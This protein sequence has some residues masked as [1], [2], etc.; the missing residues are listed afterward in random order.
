MRQPDRIPIP[1]SPARGNTMTARLTLGIICGGRSPEHQIS[2][3]SA[4]NVIKAAAESFDILVVGITRNG[5]WL[6]LP[7]QD[8]STG[9]ESPATVQLNTKAGKPVSLVRRQDQAGL[10][11]ADNAFLRLDVVFPVMHGENGEDGTIQGLLQLQGLPYVGCDVASSAV[12]MDKDLTKRLLAAS[13]IAVAPGVC[14]QAHE[15]A[16]HDAEVLVREFGLPLFIKPA[17]LGSSVGVSKVKE[18]GKL[19]EAIAEALRYDNKVLVEAAIIGREIECAVLGN[20]NPA[21]SIAGEVIPKHEFYSYEAKYLDDD[22][23][24]LKAPADLSP[25]MHEKVQRAACRAYRVLGCGGLARVDFFLTPDGQ[26]IL[27]ELNTIPGFTRISMYPKLWELTGVPQPE[28][29][30]RL[31]GLALD[32]HRKQQAL[33]GHQAL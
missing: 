31:V 22:G 13:G 15:F 17:R 9:Y 2:L 33:L 18:A 32:R 21:G 8:F 26:L 3:Q 19:R 14:I 23:A 6:L 30:R 28:L 16:E 12:C 25:E 24:D 4:R 5:E 20:E 29:M 10:L 1:T 11:T 7:T 27:N